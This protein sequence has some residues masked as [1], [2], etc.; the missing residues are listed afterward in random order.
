MIALII[1]SCLSPYNGA[2]NSGLP[3]PGAPV[4]I[5]NDLFDQLDESKYHFY[6][7]DPKYWT[8]NGYTLW[9]ML[10]G[11]ESD[12]LTTRTVKVS[13]PVG[14][15]FAGYGIVICDASRV[16]GG[17]LKKVMLTVLVNNQGQYALGKVIAGYYNSMQGWT[18]TPNL[19]KGSGLINVIKVHYN[20]DNTYSLYFN[21]N[22]TTTFS[23]NNEPKCQGLGKNGYIVVISPTDLKGSGVEVLFEE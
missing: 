1:V 19:D 6:T 8:I 15:N 14:D 17:E 23:D 10:D 3:V 2:E 9:T 5:V 22:L 13:K 18:Y 16:A 21:G 12:I 4:E 7:N 20:N 11:N